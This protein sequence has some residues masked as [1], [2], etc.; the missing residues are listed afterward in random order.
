MTGTIDNGYRGEL[1]FGVWNLLNTPV[2]VENGHRIGQLLILPLIGMS[3]EH[4]PT[5]DH[6]ERGTRGFGSTGT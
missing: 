5:L 3:I 4:V 1:M 2:V 6:S